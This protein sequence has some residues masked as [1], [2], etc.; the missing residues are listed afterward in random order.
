LIWCWLA[1][2]GAQV[3]VAPLDPAL[4]LRAPGLRV[5]AHTDRA[6]FIQEFC[7]LPGVP[8]DRARAFFDA[9]GTL[10]DTLW[11]LFDTPELLP[12]LTLRSVFAHLP[13]IGAY[14]PLL[15]WLGQPLSAFVAHFGL[16]DCAPLRTWLDAICQ[17]TVQCPSDK[18]EAPFA[19]AAIDY[20][21]HGCGHVLGGL[22]ALADA[23]VQA[24]E[25]AGGEVR[26]AD[27]VQRIERLDRG[28]RVITR[29]GAREV[30]AIFA[31]VLPQSLPALSD[32][33]LAAPHHRAERVAS[34]WSAAMLY[35][36]LDAEAPLPPGPT[37]LELVQ[38]PGA[39]LEHGNHLLVSLAARDD[40]ERA[41]AGQRVATVSTHVDPSAYA[42]DP[43]GLTA[44]VHERMRG[45]LRALAP[46]IHAAIRVEMTG[47]PRTF[48]RFTRREGGLVGGVPRTT[49]L[50]QYLDLWPRPVAQGLYLVGDS[51]MLGQSVL[52]TALGGQRTAAAALAAGIRAPRGA[53]RDVRRSPLPPDPADFQGESH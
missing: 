27:R 45:G 18:A 33:T 10:A 2:H 52:A 8:A 12:P 13:R 50:A 43:A 17:I 35:L 11:G 47:S 36:A 15:R 16:S 34:G 20:F 9:Q 22:G 32:G 5:I 44:R 42:Q 41:P 40:V 19:I 26:F 6:H 46:E 3:E 4:E 39:P 24:I 29:R 53:A 28:W 31:N 21:F 38:E 7:S 48:A 30:G 25:A 37:H 1:R 23:F 51:V 49:G 14:A